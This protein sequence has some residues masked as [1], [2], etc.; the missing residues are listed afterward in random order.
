MFQEIVE[1]KGEQFDGVIGIGWFVVVDNGGGRLG[2]AVLDVVTD[3][4]G[5]LGLQAIGGVIVGW[6]SVEVDGED[7]GLASHTAVDADGEVR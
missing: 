1:F 4:E 7:I 2:A 5:A 6:I 3:G